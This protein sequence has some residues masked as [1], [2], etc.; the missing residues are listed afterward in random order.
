MSRSVASRTRE[1]IIP[2]YLALVMQHLERSVQLQKEGFWKAALFMQDVEKLGRN[3]VSKV[4]S[5]VW[6]IRRDAGSWACLVK[7]RLKGN[8]R[9]AY[10]YFKGNY[11]D[12]CQMV[13]QVATATNCSL[14]GSSWR[15]GEISSRWEYCSTRTSYPQIK[16]NHHLRRLSRLGQKN[17]QLSWPMLAVALCQAGGW[18]R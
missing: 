9:L 7:R 2:F 16:E 13:K 1:V 12:R 5:D 4:T 6:P 8:L 3:T 17:L 11:I 10:N 14:G 15:L 18:N